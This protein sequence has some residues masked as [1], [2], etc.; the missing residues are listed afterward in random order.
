MRVNIMPISTYYRFECCFG[1]VSDRRTLRLGLYRAAVRNPVYAARD[2][3]KRIRC[4]F[5]C[6]DV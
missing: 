2:I 3:N 1:R 6:M 4:M 5:G